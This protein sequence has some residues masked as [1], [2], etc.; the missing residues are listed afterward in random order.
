MDEDDP[1]IIAVI[2]A[3]DI[4]SMDG[5]RVRIKPTTT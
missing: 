1:V 2:T 5:Y 4:D 3:M